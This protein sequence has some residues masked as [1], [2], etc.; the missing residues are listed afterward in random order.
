MADVSEDL[1]TSSFANIVDGCRTDFLIGGG[2]ATDDGDD[3]DGGGR[4]A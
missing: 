3:G 2:G 4:G 1:G